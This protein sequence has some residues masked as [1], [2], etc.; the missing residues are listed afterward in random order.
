[1]KILERL[2]V[3]FQ[4]RQQIGQVGGRAI[5]RFA[6]F[7]LAAIQRAKKRG[8]V[9]YPFQRDGAFFDGRRLWTRFG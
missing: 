1:M 3:T 2:D 7:A 9:G 4:K 8:D 5:D 6:R